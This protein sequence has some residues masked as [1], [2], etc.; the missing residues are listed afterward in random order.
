MLKSNKRKERIDRQTDRKEGR[1]N[2]KR[3]NVFIRQ[4][5]SESSST[6]TSQ[7]TIHVRPASH[8]YFVYVFVQ[9]LNQRCRINPYLVIFSLNVYFNMIIE[10]IFGFA[11]CKIVDCA[12]GFN[13]LMLLFL[14]AAA[15]YIFD[16]HQTCGCVCVFLFVFKILTCF[17][18]LYTNELLH[19]RNFPIQCST[20]K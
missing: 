6:P 12:V 5:S 10:R 19:H 8:M 1:K 4:Q 16:I 17:F 9:M 20:I 18:F 11:V 14:V 3:F 2:R 13:L 7:Q 15:R